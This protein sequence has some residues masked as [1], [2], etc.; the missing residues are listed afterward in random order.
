MDNFPYQDY[1]EGGF[2]SDSTSMD[3]DLLTSLNSDKHIS[4]ER[5]QRNNLLI[6]EVFSDQCM[7][8]V[9][10]VVTTGRLEVLRRQAESLVQHQ[11]RSVTELSTMVT[12]FKEKKEKLLQ[13]T[14]DFNKHYEKYCRPAVDSEMY[15]KMVADA[16]K[17][18]LE[19]K[20]EDLEDAKLDSNLNSL[21]PN[22]T[23]AP[24]VTPVVVVENGHDASDEESQN[25]E[26]PTVPSSA[27]VA[28]ASESSSKE[29]VENGNATTDGNETQPEESVPA[30]P[31][32]P[33]PQQPYQHQFTPPL[34]PGSSRLSRSGS[35]ED[36][37]PATGNSN[38]NSGPP[39]IHQ[40]PPSS[41]DENHQPN[42][43]SAPPEQQYPYRTGA[44]SSS[45]YPPPPPPPPSNNG[46]TGQYPPT[47]QPPP[48]PGMSHTAAQ[49]Q[50]LFNSNCRL[51]QVES[52]HPF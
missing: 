42:A 13:A 2:C 6:G 43:A 4:C 46:Y 32:K 39:P 38:V 8:D 31:S 45:K 17:Q 49:Q 23:S 9:R 30:P 11:E 10:S 25:N 7:P 22:G 5:F 44:S 51:Q 26:T 18:L 24:L 1:D 12:N 52:L 20:A 40:K 34:P 14:I 47:G 37:S 35:I 21:I 16:I 36:K 28:P 50:Q 15:E 3:A 27:P 29:V 41:H 19:R 48:L 33:T